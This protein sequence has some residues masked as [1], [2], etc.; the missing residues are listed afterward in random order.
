MSIPFNEALRIQSPV[1]A[2]LRQGNLDS[3]NHPAISYLS[4]ENTLSPWMISDGQ[5]SIKV[6]LLENIHPK[7]V[8]LFKEV[9]FSVET[10]SSSLSETELK[11]KIR[12][13]HILGIRSKTQLDQAMIEHAT[14]LL[15]IGCFCIGTNQVDLLEAEARGV[16]FFI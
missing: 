14:H 11:E 2:A 9:G 13:V 1:N 4:V 6:L 15:A 12:Y 16:C 8:S 10:L 5:K 7:G 3:T